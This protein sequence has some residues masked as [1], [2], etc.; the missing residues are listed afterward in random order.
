MTRPPFIT[1][2][3]LENGSVAYLHLPLADSDRTV[4]S[5]HFKTVFDFIDG[6]RKRLRNTLIY[7]QKGQSRSASF[8]VAYMLHALSVSGR[9]KHTSTS[10]LQILKRRYPAAEPNVAFRLQLAAHFDSH[11]GA[12]AVADDGNPLGSPTLFTHQTPLLGS[13]TS[14][15]DFTHA[16]GDV[17]DYNSP[18]FIHHGRETDDDG[19]GEENLLDQRLPWYLRDLEAEAPPPPNSSPT[20]KFAATPPPSS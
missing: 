17:L 14:V 16:F 4:L 2:E 19:D 13:G 1:D 12:A 20:A 18:Q 6:Q 9:S 15:S 5:D 3:D 7:C 10:M 8:A 11:H